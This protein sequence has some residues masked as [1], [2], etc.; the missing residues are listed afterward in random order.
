MNKQVFLAGATAFLMTVLCIIFWL[1]QG[2]DSATTGDYA[3]MAI[4]SFVYWFIL[5]YIVDEDKL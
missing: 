3:G 2:F 4:I 5:N 1:S